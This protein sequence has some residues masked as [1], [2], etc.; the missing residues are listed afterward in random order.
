MNRVGDEVDLRAPRALDLDVGR[1]QK[2]HLAAQ[3]PHLAAQK[4]HFGVERRPPLVRPGVVL[5]HRSKRGEGVHARELRAPL[6]PSIE[7]GC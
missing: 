3:K 4:P 1:V 2:P 5:C 7:R 6:A